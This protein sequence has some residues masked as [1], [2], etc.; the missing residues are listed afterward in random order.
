[1]KSILFSITGIILMG[2]LTVQGQTPASGTVVFEEKAKIEIKL[3]GEAAAMY[4]DM[5]PKERTS[6]GILEFSPEAS[7]Y[8]NAPQPV[9]DE[10]GSNFHAEGGMMIKI[11]DTE[12][13]VFI[14]LKE[15]KIIEQRDF[16][17][18]LFLVEGDFPDTEWKITGNQKMILDYPCMEATSSDENDVVTKVWFTPSI[19]VQSGPAKFCNLPGLVLEADV[20]NGDRIFTALSIDLTPPDAESFKKPKD[21]KKVSEEE[22]REIVAEKMKEMGV[23]GEPGTGG[24]RVMEI[25]IKKY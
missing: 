24:T 9:E 11:G 17:T 18:R 2:L 19:P 6:K 12:N 10:M 15:G 16:M 3:E 4:A 1:M 8:K 25:R 22:F 7:L 13:K 23:E 5:L 14:D 21:G 20:K